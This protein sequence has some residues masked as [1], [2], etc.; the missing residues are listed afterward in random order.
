MSER[1]SAVVIR[2]VAFEDLGAFEPVLAR[3]GITERTLNAGVGDLSGLDPL[4]SD[5]VIVLGGPIAATDTE[6]YPFLA[7]EVALLRTRLTTDLPT[8]GI[9]L[10][11]QLMALALGGDVGPGEKEIGLAPIELTEAG[12]RSPLAAFRGGDVLHWHGDE[13][14]LPPGATLLASTPACRTQAF[15]YGKRCLGVQF[16][17]EAAGAGF[18]RWLVG[19]AVELAAAGVDVP[20]LRRDLAA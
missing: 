5:L 15:A 10:G 1:R 19:H 4:G 20:R 7:D 16:H 3:L 18:E 17:P 9:C 11:A 2:H 13:M 6:R 12:R 14:T 8:L